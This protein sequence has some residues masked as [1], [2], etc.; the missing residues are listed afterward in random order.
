[1]GI[2]LF[3]INQ[4]GTSDGTIID[5]LFNRGDDKIFP[6]SEAS[7]II[8]SSDSAHKSGIWRFSC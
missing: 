3:N 2:Y 1:M 8:L 4:S 6:D 7:N 5:M